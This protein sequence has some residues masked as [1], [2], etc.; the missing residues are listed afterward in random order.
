MVL[1]LLKLEIGDIEISCAVNEDGT[2]VLSQTGAVKSLG[3]NRFAQLPKFVSTN[4]IAPFI[5]KDVTDL[6]NDPIKFTQ[7]PD[8]KQK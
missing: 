2:R 6:L 5:S 3:M 1:Y 7:C 8:D 4:A